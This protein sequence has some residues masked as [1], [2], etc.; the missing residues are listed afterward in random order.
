MPL[1]AL[2]LG[3]L[4]IHGIQPGPRLIS[5]QPQIFWGLIASF[6]VG[7]IMLVVLNLPLIGIWVKFLSIPGRYLRPAIVIFVCIGVYSINNSAFDLYTMCLFGLVGYLMRYFNYEPVLLIL[8]FILGPLMEQYL[9]RA[10]I[11]SSGDPGVFIERP[12]SLTFLVVSSF[13][14]LLMVYS[15]FP[16]RAKRAAEALKGEQH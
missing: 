3:V 9:R 14:L 15:T 8:G 16:R 7:N 11:L 6:W 4:I 13:F 10:M 2:M 1:M 5:E 12:I